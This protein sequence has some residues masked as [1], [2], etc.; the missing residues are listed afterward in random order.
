M[1]Y[2]LVLFYLLPGMNCMDFERFKTLVECEQRRTELIQDWH[3][4]KMNTHCVEMIDG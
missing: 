3:Y 1:K 2:I 4:K